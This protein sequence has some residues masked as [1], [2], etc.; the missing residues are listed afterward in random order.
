MVFQQISVLFDDTL[1]KNVIDKLISDWTI[2]FFKPSRSHHRKR[3]KNNNHRRFHS[4]NLK[5]IRVCY[6]PDYGT[7]K[8][9]SAYFLHDSTVL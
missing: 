4:N 6:V 3:K 1:K 5:N 7:S 8:M 9:V 2:I